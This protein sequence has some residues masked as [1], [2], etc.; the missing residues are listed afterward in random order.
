MF[1]AILHSVKSFLLSDWLLSSVFGL[2][3]D[4]VL[5]YVSSGLHVTCR[6]VGLREGTPHITFLF[7]VVEIYL[8]IAF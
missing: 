7:S 6:R 8:K 3:L 4:Y 1:S 2:L 5:D